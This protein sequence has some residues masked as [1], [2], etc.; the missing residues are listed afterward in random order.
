[1]KIID[2][3]ERKKK[4]RQKDARRGASY[5]ESMRA[6]WFCCPFKFCPI[7]RQGFFNF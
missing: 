1:M 2:K 4:Q 6:K 5:S 3:R 7:N